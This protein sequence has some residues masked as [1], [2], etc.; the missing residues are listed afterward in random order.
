MMPDEL[1]AGCPL[2]RDKDETIQKLSDEIL[3]LHQIN[4]VLE[5]LVSGFQEAAQLHRKLA[6][7]SIA[8]NGRLS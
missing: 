1:P 6:L 3:Y 7:R 4:R 2:C 8:R 5:D